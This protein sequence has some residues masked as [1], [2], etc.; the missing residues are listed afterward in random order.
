MTEKEALG[1]RKKV[2]AAHRASVT[3]TIAQTQDLL[4]SEDGIEPTKLKQKC[5]AL[6]A[7]AELLNKL[8]ADIVEAV[9]EDELDEE[10]DSA[11]TV[12]ERIELAIIELDSALAAAATDEDNHRRGDVRS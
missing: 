8:D 5:E 11:D 12:R 3:R 9:D 6:A 4:G 7:K 10:I 2:R 1:R